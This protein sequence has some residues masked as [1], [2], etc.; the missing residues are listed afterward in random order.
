[1]FYLLHL[2][3]LAQN[4]SA[5]ACLIKIQIDGIVLEGKWKNHNNRDYLDREIL[6]TKSFVSQTEEMVSGASCEISCGINNIR[7]VCSAANT[8]RA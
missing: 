6:E 5:I 8:E 1:M 4:P 7:S 3:T 2:I